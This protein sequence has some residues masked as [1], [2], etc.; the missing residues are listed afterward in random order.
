MSD[1]EKSVSRGKDETMEGKRGPK[2]FISA[3]LL[4][5]S[6]VANGSYV[7]AAQPETTDASANRPVL[8]PPTE[9]Q[10]KRGRDFLDKL[11]Y[12]IENVSL[13][14]AAAVMK[15]FGFSNLDTA[16]YP[17]YVRVQPVRSVISKAA[18]LEYLAGTGFEAISVDPLV[19]SKSRTTEAVANA[20]FDLTIVCVSIDDVRARFGHVAN[21]RSKP[22]RLPPGPRPRD[23]HDTGYLT[24]EPLQTPEGMI[25]RLGFG[26][27]YQVCAKDYAFAYDNFIKGK[28]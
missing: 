11:S 8:A 13:R 6:I 3:V 26:F 20:R 9:D 1:H 18:S 7:F 14:D 16:I 24:F 15:V 12:I 21:I 28:N 19:R 2:V 10:L 22:T 5:V 27:D 17:T 25:G 4:I 23:V